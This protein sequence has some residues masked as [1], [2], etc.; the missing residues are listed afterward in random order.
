MTPCLDWKNHWKNQS[1]YI[2]NTFNSTVYYII[3]IQTN[4]MA[5][6]CVSHIAEAI[7]AAAYA[8]TTTTNLTIR[9]II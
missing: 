3:T 4:T 5:T 6:F 8:T 7:S 9:L 2:L 1:Y